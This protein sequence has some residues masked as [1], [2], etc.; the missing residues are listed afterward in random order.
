MK[1]VIT[2]RAPQDGT[3]LGPAIL[4][5]KCHSE[6]SSLFMLIEICAYYLDNMRL[7]DVSE[8]HLT[9]DSIVKSIDSIVYRVISPIS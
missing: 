9:I 5:V 2:T 3:V 6:T 1:S 8:C 7:E 4:V